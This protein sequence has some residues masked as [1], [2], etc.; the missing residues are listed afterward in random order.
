VQN[1]HRECGARGRRTPEKKKNLKFFEKNIKK[2]DRDKN[3]FYILHNIKYL[4]LFQEGLI[5]GGS[6]LI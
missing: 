3:V 1:W 6:A 2:V 5:A 4:W